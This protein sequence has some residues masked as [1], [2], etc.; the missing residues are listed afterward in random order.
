MGI[1]E[2]LM[3]ETIL[4]SWLLVFVAAAGD[5][6]PSIA[7]L[8]N[9][10]KTYP[11]LSFRFE[12]LVYSDVFESVDTVAGEVWVGRDGRFRLAMPSQELVSN[13]VL[14]WSYSVENEQVVIDSVHDLD[15]WN[16]LTLVY[17]PER[18]YACQN[19]RSEKGT[20]IFRLAARDTLTRPK[21]FEL[22]V[23]AKDQVPLMVTYRDENDSRIEV[24]ILK[25]SRY[26]TRPADSLFQFRVPPGVEVIDLP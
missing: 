23:A 16:P 15:G 18:V 9:T 10:Y 2:A 26:K 1:I 7:D 25:F 11:Y 24:S 5:T 13:G 19:E 17:D 12:Q 14:Y 21:E 22:T 3:A 20:T 8:V 6:C 4:I